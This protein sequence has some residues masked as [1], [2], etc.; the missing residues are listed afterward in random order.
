MS[1]DNIV[2][3]CSRSEVPRRIQSGATTPAGERLSVQINRNLGIVRL[4]R[5]LGAVGLTVRMDVAANVIVIE[6]GDF[7][8]VCP[9][10]NKVHNGASC[11]AEVTP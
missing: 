4:L 1:N 2:P 10:C 5:G 9:G 6:E 3:L 11:D 8:R 7:T